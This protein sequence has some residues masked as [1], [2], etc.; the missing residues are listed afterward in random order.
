MPS[1]RRSRVNKFDTE[2]ENNKTLLKNSMSSKSTK[3]KIAG[4]ISRLKR[5]ERKKI[6]LTDTE[7]NTN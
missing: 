7:T 3:N 2:F 1:W 4:Y 6:T 5:M